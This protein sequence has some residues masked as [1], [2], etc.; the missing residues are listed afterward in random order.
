MTLWQGFRAV[1]LTFTL[2]LTVTAPVLAGGVKAGFDLASPSAGPFPS[3]IFTVADPSH[4]TGLRVSLPKPNCAARPTDCADIDVINVLDGFNLQP[5]ITVSFSGAINVASVNSGNV[6]FLSL[7]DTLG[8]AGGQVIGINQIVWDPVSKTLHAESDELLDQHTRYALIVTNGIRDTAGDPVEAGAFATFRR[9]LNFGQTKNAT[10]KAYRKSLLDAIDASG[11]DPATIVTASVFS[12]Q[13]ATAVLEKIRDRI[14]AMPVT[15]ATILASFPRAN[16]A[17][18]QWNRQTRSNGSTTSSFVAL[19]ALDVFPGAVGRIVFGR[20]SSPDWE[21]P[22][23]VIPAVGTLTG[24][25]AVQSVNTLYFNLFVPAGTPPAGGW[26]VAIFG[27]GFTDSKQGAPTA[28]ASTLA[29]HGI[30]TIA[31]NVVGHG[32]GG[33]T[34]NLTIVPLTGAPVTI[35]DGGRG[36]DQDGNGVI[37]STEGSS[38]APPNGLVGS[39]DG[40]RQTVAD[41][42]QLVRVLQAGV[43]VDGDGVPDLNGRRIYYAGQS[44]GGIYGVKF[45]AV[46]P[47]IRAGVP[48]VP[49]GAIIEIARL[50]PA[51][52]A[53][54][55]I[56]LASRVPSLCNAGTLAPPLWCF[57]ES[58]PLRDDPAVTAP[59][60]GAMPIQEVI[61]NTEWVSQAGNPVAYAPHLRKIPLDGVPTRPFIIQNA[62]G[63]QTVPNPTSSAIVRAGDIHDRWTLFRNDLV[64]AALP[65]AQTNPHT[66]LTNIGAA[67]PAVAAL[68]IAAQN[69]IGIFF[70]SDG[71]VVV[72]PDGTGPFFEVPIAAD[73][74]PLME[75]LNL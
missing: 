47:D 35:P 50:S 12:T 44:F 39:R 29:H 67:N 68:S 8:G 58:I 1:T 74:I 23:K 3:N 20:F 6:F 46:E 70:E 64:R 27:H 22:G 4:N 73:Q 13:S 51:F 59:A 62:K 65:G 16:V 15:P 43:D 30:A 7:G 75:D 37:D 36:I 21:T 11:L 19:P 17:A 54:V 60:P 5:R 56:A 25:P 72:D 48:N 40:L 9:D 52:R 61:D 41:L 10:L 33:T 34:G 71:A 53:L 38:A 69:Q 55:G 24:V 57:Q 49:G 26:P 14:K 45:I 32:G 18:I 63:D 66:F 2:L 28:V 42:M 31:I